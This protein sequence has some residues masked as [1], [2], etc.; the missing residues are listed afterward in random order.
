ME[1]QEVFQVLP[2]SQDRR[3]KEASPTQEV[4]VSLGPR[5]RED[6]QVRQRLRKLVVLNRI[7][8]CHNY[9]NGLSSFRVSGGPGLPGFPGRPGPPGP[10]VGSN[11]PGPLGDP[12][13]P[14]LDG[15]YGKY[16]SSLQFPCLFFSFISYSFSIP[17]RFLLSPQ[18]FQGP[19]GPPGPPGPGTAQGDRGDSGLPGF[20]GSPGIKGEPGR[21]GGPGSP[22]YPGAKGK[23]D[24]KDSTQHLHISQPLTQPYQ[25]PQ[26][27][28]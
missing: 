24:N 23:N 7:L 10:T 2:D 17:N 8:Q 4:Q 21:N 14:G 22:G 16:I 27:F 11:V 5:E 12:G 19:P 6:S 28:L 18:G 26:N 13:L 1:V 3:E 20:P 25:V 15:E 9:D